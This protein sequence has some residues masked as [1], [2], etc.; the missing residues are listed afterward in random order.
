MSIIMKKKDKINDTPTLKKK[1]LD[2]N[3]K[4]NIW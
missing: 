1:I 2:N 3:T 4:S